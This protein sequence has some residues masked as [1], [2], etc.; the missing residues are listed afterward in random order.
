MAQEKYSANNLAIGFF[1]LKQPINYKFSISVSFADKLHL[2]FIGRYWQKETELYEFFYKNVTMNYLMMVFA[3][4]CNT[5]NLFRG[6]GL[7][8]EPSP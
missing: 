2:K 4:A 5:S 3:G 8:G 7:H 1:V 6:N